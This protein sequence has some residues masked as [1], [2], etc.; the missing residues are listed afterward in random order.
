MISKIKYDDIFT[1]LGYHET[2]DDD[3]RARAED[4][5]YRSFDEGYGFDFSAENFFDEM[6]K[7]HLYALFD[8]LEAFDKGSVHYVDLDSVNNPTD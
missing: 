7:H 4:A 8:H 3:W 1:E 2:I 6:T 5:I